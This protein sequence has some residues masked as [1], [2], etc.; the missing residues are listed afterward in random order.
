MKVFTFLIK[1]HVK[2]SGTL[3]DKPVTRLRQAE[4]FKGASWFK[5][6]VVL[7]AGNVHPRACN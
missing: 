1:E 3:S 6:L 2:L 7:W 5:K 4:P